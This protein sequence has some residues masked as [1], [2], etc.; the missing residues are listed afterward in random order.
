M[1]VKQEQLGDLPL[2]GH[3]LRSSGLVSCLDRHFPVHGNWG[4]PSVGNMVMCWLMYIISECD[5]RLYTVEEWACGHILTLR[6]AVGDP[7]LAASAFQDDRLGQILERFSSEEAWTSMM[8]DHNAGLIQL[9]DLPEQ[10]VRVDSVNATSYREPKEGGLFQFG[11]R[12]NHQ[13]RL[14]HLKTMLTSLDPLALPLSAFVVQGKRS[15]D[16][17]YVPAI[18]QARQGLRKEGVLYVGDTKLCNLD[19]CAYL[20][21]SDNFYLGPLSEVQYGGEV[22]RQSILQAWSD[23]ASMQPLYKEDPKTGLPK[24]FAKVYELPQRERFDPSS[25]IGWQER[26]ILVRD[27]ERAQSQC[28]SLR[29]RLQNAQRELLER[30][31]PRKRRVTWKTGQEAE[32]RAFVDKILARYKVAQLLEVEVLTPPNGKAKAPIYVR[33]NVKQQVVQDMELLAGWRVYATNA[34]IDRLHTKD[35]LPCYRDEYRIEQQFHKLLTKTTNLLPI[36]LKNENRIVAMLRLL[37]LALQFVAILQHT[38]R[39][40]LD[41]QKDVLQDIVPGNKGRKIEKPTAEAVL[42]RFCPVTAVWVKNPQQPNR[43][44]LM[45]FDPIHLKIIQLLKCPEDLYQNMINEY[46]VCQ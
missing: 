32:V 42:K 12:K 46:L 43:A 23:E 37:T 6:W 13:A 39:K 7:N 26:L 24:A 22:L 5:H 29:E 2:L 17:L 45:N 20:A 41:E 3:L 27:D 35:I 11:H 31:L 25:H 44:F 19:N 15:D 34:P 10:T 8:A 21:G 1:E 28:A 40:E 14:P 33:A 4:G 38:I 30:F 9:Y 36:Y 18:K 16:Q